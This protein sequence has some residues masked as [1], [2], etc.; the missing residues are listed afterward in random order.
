[1]MNRLKKNKGQSLIIVIIATLLIMV[2]S[3]VLTTSVFNELKI[4]KNY[5]SRVKLRYM[6]QAGLEDSIY[7]MCK[8]INSL[9]SESDGEIRKEDNKTTDGENVI[10]SFDRTLSYNGMELYDESSISGV[11]STEFYDKNG[12]KVSKIKAYVDTDEN[13]AY[14][15]SGID[16]VE[17]KI[18]TTAEIY[19]N[20]VKRGGYNMYT[21]VLFKIDIESKKVSGYQI[22]GYQTNN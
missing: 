3:A 15:V 6:A 21:K 1:M 18:K 9:L 20:G 10:T 16:I 19:S 5:E 17:F 12:N 2:L 13:D 22:Y 8:T 11:C 14:Y 4:K 7:N